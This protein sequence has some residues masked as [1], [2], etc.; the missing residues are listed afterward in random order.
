MRIK[1]DKS[2]TYVV[3]QNTRKIKKKL[4]MYNCD[5]YTNCISLLNK[6]LIK[7]GLNKFKI[8]FLMINLYYY[9]IVF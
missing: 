9:F 4:N 5:S 6:Y 3:K 7:K 1:R 2:P 8:I